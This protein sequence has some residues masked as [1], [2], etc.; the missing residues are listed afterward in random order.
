MRNR[1]TKIA[2]A[3]RAAAC[4]L[5]LSNA[6]NCQ[7][8]TLNVA[9]FDRAGAPIPDVAVYAVPQ[10]GPPPRVADPPPHAI[11]DQVDLEF[12]PHVLIV[13]TGT[14]VDFP[15][16][17]HVNHHV[18]SFSEAKSFELPL[19]KGSV[20]PPL[21]FDEPGLVTL[22]C[23]I[24]DNMLGYILVADTPWFAMT[25]ASGEAR[26]DTLPAGRYRVHAWTPRSDRRDLPAGQTVDL[27]GGSE[28]ALSFR[29]TKELFPPH[30]Q[31]GSLSWSAY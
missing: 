26:L 30:G 1:Q 14:V 28:A 17:D 7:A 31:D 22:G 19:Y 21:T 9:V 24:H 13:Q 2:L 6:L 12:V 3:H 15:N 20:Y 11:M 4:L 23:N 16:S 5:A 27:H 18:Y 8:A 10:D 25:D 29:F